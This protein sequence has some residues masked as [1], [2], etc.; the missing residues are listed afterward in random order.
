MKYM[1]AVALPGRVGMEECF[2]DLIF[3]KLG[4]EDLFFWWGDIIFQQLT[5]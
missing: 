5:A 2:L 1:N 4:T 3:F